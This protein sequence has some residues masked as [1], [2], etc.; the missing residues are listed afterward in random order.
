MK[1]TL[2][3]AALLPATF[4]VVLATASPV[5]AGDAPTQCEVPAFPNNEVVPS[6]IPNCETILGLCI[7]FHDTPE[8][9]T[10]A[11]HPQGAATIPP[12]GD[13]SAFPPEC[14]LEVFQP[15]TSGPGRAV[16]A[17]GRLLP[18]GYVPGGTFP[19]APQCFDLPSTGFDITPVLAA[20][21]VMLAAGVV[22]TGVRRRLA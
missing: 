8:G 4:G 14:V 16:H 15:G 13:C 1:R 18:S 22:V 11:V 3:V 7:I 6:G 19:L 21:I 10:R 2:F 17:A 9:P 20:G 5:H 12:N